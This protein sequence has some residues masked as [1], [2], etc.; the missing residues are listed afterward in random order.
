M[1][2]LQRVEPK[3]QHLASKDKVGAVL[4]S[5]SEFCGS[6][7]SSTLA[8]GYSFPRN[9]V[10]GQPTRVFLEQQEKLDLVAK[11]CLSHHSVESWPF[12]Q[13]SDL[14]NAQTRAPGLKGG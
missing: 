6:Q 12:T 11:A 1:M 5:Y 10:Y 14:V 4:N 13:F 9:K 3:W 8:I 7:I 2:G